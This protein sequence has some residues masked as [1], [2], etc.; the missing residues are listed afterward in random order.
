MEAIGITSLP[1]VNAGHI[2]ERFMA[3]NDKAGFR[4]AMKMFFRY[5]CRYGLA[6]NDV[7]RFIPAVPRHKPVPSV[8]TKDETEKILDS[9]NR[10][11]GL[12]KR[13][14]CI[15]LMAARLGIRSCDIAGLKFEDI[16]DRE[17]IIRITQ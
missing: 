6:E 10:T 15:I 1:M 2:H 4:K 8:Y 12:G 14:H 16:R 5:A 3:E 11:T 13:N 7:S 17:G 9:M